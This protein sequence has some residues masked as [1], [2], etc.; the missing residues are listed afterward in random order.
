MGWLSRSIGRGNDLANSS[1]ADAVGR[2]GFG[3]NAIF[4]T[5]YLVAL[6]ILFVGALG[7]QQTGEIRGEFLSWRAG[8]FDPR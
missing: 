5:T 2:R 4:R 3:M 6:V 1:F 8:K 7:A